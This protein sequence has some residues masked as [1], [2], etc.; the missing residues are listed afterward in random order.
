LRGVWANRLKVSTAP[1]PQPDSPLA[2][3]LPIP[4]LILAGFRKASWRR[5]SSWPVNALKGPSL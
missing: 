2:H 5:W 4:Q 3:G 1:Q